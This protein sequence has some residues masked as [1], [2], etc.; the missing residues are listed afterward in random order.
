MT[1]SQ[2]A[3]D[4]NGNWRRE[5]AHASAITALAVSPDGSRFVSVG[6][7]GTARVWWVG[8]GEPVLTYRGH[9]HEVHGAAWSPDGSFIATA[10]SDKSVQVWDAATGALRLSYPGHMRR[11]LAVAWSPDGSFIAS[12]G[13]DRLVQVWDAATGELAYSYAHSGIVTDIAFSA[14]GSRI[15]TAGGMVAVYGWSSA[16]ASV[17]AL[18]NHALRHHHFGQAYVVAFSP[19][20]TLLASAGMAGDIVVQETESGLPRLT[21]KEHSN[22][23]CALAWLPETAERDCEL[24]VAS[25]GHIGDLRVWDPAD[26]HTTFDRL[27][28]QRLSAVAALRDGR[29]LV[30]GNQLG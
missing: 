14:D 28:D 3:S 18:L 30:L 9:V 22:T 2:G 26:G 17:Y 11:V 21:Y 16:E 1:I 20:G 27:A 15:A 29:T 5:A 13:E 19:D 25:V 8:S 24:E 10:G 4:K 7:E 23:V 6:W 12:G